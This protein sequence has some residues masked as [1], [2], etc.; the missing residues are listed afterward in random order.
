MPPR[1]RYTKKKVVIVK[2]R[3]RKQTNKLAPGPQSFFPKHK[4]VTLK[5]AQAYNYTS[6]D[7]TVYHGVNLQLN[8]AYNIE[9]SLTSGLT[10]MSR[11]FS[12]AQPYYFDQIY[13]QYENYVVTKTK[14]KV[15][16]TAS[17]TINSGAVSYI[18]N[19]FICTLRDCGDNST[20]PSDLQLEMCRPNCGVRYTEAGNAVSITKTFDLPKLAGQ[21]LKEYMSDSRNW[22]V[23]GGAPS[24]VF[25]A[26]AMMYR[27][28]NSI[29]RP[30]MLVEVYQ[31][32]VFFE[33][34]QIAMS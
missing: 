34:N 21:S 22:G 32:L 3:T 27:N 5:Y 25:Y 17:S 16:Y 23:N 28:G 13:P 12:N 10:N 19:A 33:P 9:G 26:N 2:K 20:I 6:G 4:A 15:T 7:S 14:V 8:N 31:T 11:L 30:T 18:D 24:Q 29:N 1:K